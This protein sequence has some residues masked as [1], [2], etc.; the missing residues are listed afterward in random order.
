MQKLGYKPV[1]VIGGILVFVPPALFPAWEAMSFW[2]FL[3]MVI[4]IGD[5]MVHFGT[6]TWVTTSVSVEKSGRS[7][8][9]YGLFFAIGFTLGPL[10]TR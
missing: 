6:Q 2:F 10:M 1:I 8:A 7:I 9:L 3:R 5:Q 4:G